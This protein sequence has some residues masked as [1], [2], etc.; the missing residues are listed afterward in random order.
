M[1][2]S[3]STKIVLITKA[4]EK[5]GFDIANKLASDH[6]DYHIIM[7]GRKKEELDQSVQA[8]RSQGCSAEG[9]LLELDSEES[10]AGVVEVIS[11]KHGRVD[12]LINNATVR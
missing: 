5:L 11:Q 7:T 6:K 1:A 3:T 9:F 4:D 10:I 2:H 12:V 8:L